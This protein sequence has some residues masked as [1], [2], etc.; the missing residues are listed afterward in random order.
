MNYL[1]RTDV[2]V[3]IGTG[4]IVRCLTLAQAL[5]NKNHK[6]IFASYQLPKTWQAQL[7]ASNFEFLE[8]NDIREIIKLSDKPD[9]LI[10]DHYELD[11]QWEK[12]MAPHVGKI[13]VIDD[14]ANRPHECDLLLDQN[15]YLNMEVRYAEL[16]S[17]KCKLLLGPT[18]ALLRP[19]FYEARKNLKTRDGA[20]QRLLLFFGGADQA[21]ETTKALRAL[22]EL[23]KPKLTYDIVIG[24]MNPHSR[25]IQDIM[26]QLPQA[27]LHVQIKNMAE[28]ISQADLALGA[29]GTATWERCFLGL[30]A[31]TVQ[32]AENQVEM[33]QALAEKGIIQNLG[34]HQKVSIDDWRSQIRWAVD[35]PQELK[36]MS[37]RAFEIMGSDGSQVN[38]NHLKLIAFL[39]K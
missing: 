11:A 2:S 7:K 4:H 12:L 37:D 20:V 3:E 32:V 1:I 36:N 27:K 34:W 39:Q 9:F 22:L 14:L 8:L 5:K 15:Y 21:G 38:E 10:V 25:E 6:V 35:N 19:E 16:V 30:P 23:N 26:K 17:K 13:A 24:S 29:G 28:L 31:L 33:S 18:F